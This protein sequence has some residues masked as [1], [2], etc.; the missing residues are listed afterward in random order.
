MKLSFQLCKVH[1]F[2]LTIL[3]V[4][5]F[6]LSTQTASAEEP[7][8]R[9]LDALK[10]AGYFD[11]AFDYLSKAE[12]NDRI[13]G[14][15]RMRIPYE[16]A[17]LLIDG[18]D[19]V[20]DAKKREDNLNQ[21]KQLLDQFVKENQ[22]HSYAP[23]AKS[24][25]SR[26]L[27]VRARIK[28]RRSKTKDGEAAEALV[29]EAQTMYNEAAKVLATTREELV[30]VLK[31]I[32]P[33]SDDPIR[34]KQLEKYRS[35]FLEVRLNL[36]QVEEEKADTLPEGSPER[37]AALERAVAQYRVFI[38][39]YRQRFAALSAKLGLARTYVKLGNKKEA[40]T[41]V[42][43]LLTQPN[44]NELRTIKRDATLMMLETWLQDKDYFL[45]I[46]KIQ[47]LF[48]SSLPFEQED[49]KWQQL[50]LGLASAYRGF[51]M[52]LK[53]KKTTNAKEKSQLNV[54]EKR[55]V[56]IARTIA[57][58]Q[59]PFKKQAQQYLVDW[60][61]A[62]APVTAGPTAPLSFAE[63]RDQASKHIADVE[64]SKLALKDLMF[65][66]SSASETE[67]PGL[68]KEIEEVKQTI[69]QLFSNAIDA[70]R[71]GL[72]L[73]ESDTPLDD[74]NIS[75]YKLCY[76]Y[77]NRK[78]HLE[79]AAIG[80]F[81][82]DFY[83]E[84]DAAKL[85]AEM[86]I[87][88]LNNFLVANKTTP[89]VFETNLLN[90]FCDVALDIW[91]SEM[92]GIK[93]ASIKI[94]LALKKKDVEGALVFLDRIPPGSNGRGMLELESGKAVWDQYVLL[95]AEIRKGVREGSINPNEVSAKQAKMKR[96]F[97]VAEKLLVGGLE[98]STQDGNI[99]V[100]IA[101]GSL[102]LAQLYLES[103]RV[104]KAIAQLEDP[105][106]GALQLIKNK[107]PV[108]AQSAF[109]LKSYQVALQTYV[110][111]IA[112]S[113]DKELM[114]QKARGIMT[115]LKNSLP[116][117]PAGKKR[118]VSIYLRLASD[119]QRQM[120]SLPTIEKKSEYATGLVT[121]L[122]EVR[123][124]SGDKSRLIWV[125]STFSTLGESFQTAGADSKAYFD[126]AV[127]A[128][129]SIL[130]KAAS[131]EIELTQ[132]ETLEMK[133]RLA[134]AS[135]ESGDFKAAMDLYVQVLTEKSALVDI[136]VEA[137]KTLQDWGTKSKDSQPLA[138][139][140]MGGYPTTKNGKKENVIWGWG[141][142]G[143]VLAR[144]EK[145]REVFYNS[146]FKLAESRLE[147]AMLKGKSKKFMEMAERDITFTYQAFPSLGGEKW[148]TKFNALLVKVQNALGKRA[149]GLPKPSK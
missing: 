17:S 129:K 106:V 136:Q 12:K 57:R 10:D 20:N 86:S 42:N 36:A 16:K 105:T 51:A 5:I 62:R 63:A 89:N 108:T 4:A 50:H 60:K 118:L 132:P 11:V 30:A 14:Q 128:Y 71:T 32:D 75:R 127:T 53:A 120:G 116:E 67:G 134:R 35:S 149:V 135:S 95:N 101:I 44:V 40:L 97:P 72:K 87:T 49:Q 25:L 115:A 147:Y 34:R 1:R 111:G 94:R 131:K 140:M 59:G 47:P 46:E 126:Q 117:T 56:D 24:K 114:T 66:L 77:A 91:P 33:K 52:E 48:D 26:L 70:L 38:E 31:R 142:L 55:S 124:E 123:K 148:T 58:T 99:N 15:I 69:D 125:A 109:V 93:A 137:A 107:H 133:R 22:Y 3:V 139:A 41:F 21:A 76:C 78:L 13:P 28:V 82:V 138:K 102:A 18:I 90:S 113:S 9:Y 143:K 7:V 84:T 96:Y 122:E 39:K 37:K 29:A 85:S 98:N 23:L 64:S 79:T 104:G 54:A 103:S 27:I 130:D 145:F 146:R 65:Q 43:E 19:S 81:L 92:V 110:S 6:G 45:A 112:E 74:I 141:K 88:A 144:N 100:N 61:V 2:A 80:K 68:Q 83:P 8:E 73:A 121:F 119:I